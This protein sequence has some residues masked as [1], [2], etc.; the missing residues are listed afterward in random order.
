MQRPL[1]KDDIRKLRTEV[2]FDFNQPGQ[3][4][5]VF[6]AVLQPVDVYAPLGAYY[7]IYDTLRRMV[8]DGFEHGE[9]EEEG[10][11]L[12]EELRAY[13]L[14]EECRRTYTPGPENDYLWARVVVVLTMRVFAESGEGDI[15]EDLLHAYLN[16]AGGKST[17]LILAAIQR[18]YHVAG[19]TPAGG[20]AFHFIANMMLLSKTL[21]SH[22]MREPKYQS[23]DDYLDLTRRLNRH[24]STYTTDG[25]FKSLTPGDDYCLGYLRDQWLDRSAPQP[26]NGAKIG[27]CNFR[28]LDSEEKPG[29]W[30]PRR[31]RS[32]REEPIEAAPTGIRTVTAVMI[33]PSGSGKTTMVRQ[34]VRANRQAV[35]LGV[36]L[37]ILYGPS[38]E[39]SIKVLEE[40][41]PP[42]TQQM[43]RLQA[44]LLP[45]Q[46]PPARGQAEGATKTLFNIH[47]SKGGSMFADPPPLDGGAGL[48]ALR[49]GEQLDSRSE[50]E[51]L[52]EV[53]AMAD[54]LVLFIPPEFLAESR[55][56]SA[57]NL[58]TLEMYFSNFIAQVAQWNKNA[59]I[60]FAYTKCDE[61]GV[62]LNRIRR[63]V[64][65][66][67][68]CA[69][70][71]A[72]R[73]AEEP[74]EALWQAFVSAASRRGDGGESRLV[75]DLL[76]RTGVL[77]K[78]TLRNSRH[79]FLNG[80][81]V[82][83]EPVVNNI[84]NGSVKARKNWES[85]GLLQIFADFF[86]HLKATKI[87]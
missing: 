82:A 62:R 76:G 10:V 67:A 47:D 5:P 73:S 32:A 68:A 27:A 13:F 22:Y 23:L 75:S 51:R 52:Y 7:Q 1:S 2:F 31:P 50:G 56:V 15:P 12:Y 65:D 4:S 25:K 49:H 57:I 72:Y 85:L 3:L 78:T 39:G 19:R 11:K 8:E 60:A 40:A 14:S 59:M 20:A 9:G 44:Y 6:K 74:R 69:A 77:W 33:G 83:A 79:R 55:Q 87:I 30:W 81:L 71:E 54:L 29:G 18:L 86:A 84:G 46:P 17:E 58:S 66:E 36:G 53:A 41:P 37:Q 61:Y 24:D 38:H 63:V 26:A 45:L 35:E 16:T 64:K 21:S 42:G 70:M 34:L 80:Y 43:L 28:Y 48:P